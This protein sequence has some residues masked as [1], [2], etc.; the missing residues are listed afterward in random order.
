M[1]RHAVSQGPNYIRRESSEPGEY[2]GIEY[3]ALPLVSWLFCIPNCPNLFRDHFYAD[4]LKR[5]HSMCDINQ[6]RVTRPALQECRLIHRMIS[7]NDANNSVVRDAA[8]VGVYTPWPPLP[9]W[10]N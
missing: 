5:A 4:N 1:H 2:A 8:V 6:I 3:A 7:T 10:G 9:R